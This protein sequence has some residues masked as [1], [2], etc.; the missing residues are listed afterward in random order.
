MSL[1]VSLNEA[2]DRIAPSESVSLMA[3]VKKLQAV[4]PTILNMTGGEPDFATPAAVCEE[5]YRAMMAG[6]T[7]YGDS[8]GDP[9]LRAAI[10]EKLFKENNAPYSPE[11]ILV[12]PGGKY[13]IYVAIQALVNPGDEVL[14]LTPGWVS[15]PA[16]VTLCGGTPVAVNL[17]YEE[18]YR[19][20]TDLLEEKTTGK[21]KLLILNYPNNPTGCVLSEQEL[22]DLKAY[23]RRH[24]N[25]LVLSDEI[26]E[27]LVY[28]GAR[29][30]T[31][32]SDPEFFERVMI[33]NGFSKCAAMTGWR[34]GYLACSPDLY[35]AVQKI[36]QHSMS[37]TSTFVQKA[38]MVA[39]KLPGETERMRA[40]YES[41]RNLIYNGLKDIP[42]IEF[43][44]PSGAFY[45]W[46][47]F[48]TDLDSKA[49]CAR[50]LE[51]AGIGGVPGAAYGEKQVCMV[52]FC[53]AS[54]ET[55]LTQFVERMRRFC[56]E[57][58]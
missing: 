56:A 9:E 33:V 16:I 5:A 35:P 34:I 8:K 4:D 2:L 39:L 13:A 57:E 52:R 43:R 7:H 23:L 17:R 11:H 41:R 47:R 51:K 46:I 3:A 50:L 49:V 28:D 32:A 42:N 21:T 10:A 6:C 40:A 24:P 19:L 31:P 44:L 36:F 15:Y 1:P 25:V 14:W 54:N 48:K 58:L 22:A 29:A 27:K 38:A 26:Y 20:N 37:C 55:V 53:Y 45:A 12:T 30:E 18:G